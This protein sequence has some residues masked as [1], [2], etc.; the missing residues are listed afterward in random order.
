M[1]NA[2]AWKKWSKVREAFGASSETPNR[3]HR[4][5]GVERHATSGA[6]AQRPLMRDLTL[7]A[8]D[9]QQR[10]DACA[11]GAPCAAAL[12]PL[13]QLCTAGKSVGTI[14]TRRRAEDGPTATN[15]RSEGWFGLMPQAASRTLASLWWRLAASRRVSAVAPVA[16]RRSAEGGPS[17]KVIWRRE[18]RW[19]KAWAL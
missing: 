15:R 18:G 14:P 16:R 6:V 7:S 2:N 10:A 19:R 13:R 5:Q 8:F 3:S 11:G 17:Q 1:K 9:W 4:T 12:S